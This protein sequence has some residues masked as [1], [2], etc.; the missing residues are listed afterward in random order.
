MNK[1]QLDNLIN[2][3]VL[4]RVEEL[5][6]TSPD[7]IREKW[8]S[9]IGNPTLKDSNDI[10]NK[11]ESDNDKLGYKVNFMPS[12]WCEKW[13]VDNWEEIKNII[14][15]IYLITK[16]ASLD[17]TYILKYYNMFFDGYGEVSS[18]VKV[19]P[20]LDKKINMWLE[21]TRIKRDYRLNLLTKKST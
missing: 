17:I 13:R 4:F 1:T 6:K 16:P 10:I 7:Y 20:V 5:S 8:L 15:F 9:F 18:I 3:S 21:T 11:L 19:H 2:F 12:D 14:Y